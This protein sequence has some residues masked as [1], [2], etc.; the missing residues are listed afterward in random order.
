V[1]RFHSKKD[2]DSGKKTVEF[3]PVHTDQS[4]I[5]Y[6]KF[7]ANCFKRMVETDLETMD[8]IMIDG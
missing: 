1:S 3:S 4:V 6:F 2:K 5:P 7:Q 8:F